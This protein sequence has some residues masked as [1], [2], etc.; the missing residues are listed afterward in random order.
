MFQIKLQE[1]YSVICGIYHYFHR[2]WVINIFALEPINKID[3]NDGN[4]SI[5]LSMAETD[6]LDD[7]NVGNKNTTINIDFQQFDI[8]NNSKIKISETSQLT[9]YDSKKICRTI[10][11]KSNFF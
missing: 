9:L 3:G 5:E 6:D 8:A 7:S 11:F 10:F 2:R 4:D 1:H